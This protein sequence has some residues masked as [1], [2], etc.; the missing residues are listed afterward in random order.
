[1][2]NDR[3]EAI[4]VVVP[5]AAT[6]VLATSCYSGRTSIRPARVGMGIGEQGEESM[7]SNIFIAFSD[8][9]KRQTRS[10]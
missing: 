10:G 6:L 9:K 2:E 5:D 8:S 7:H 4:L 3:V 1:M